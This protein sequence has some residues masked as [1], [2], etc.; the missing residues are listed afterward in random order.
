ML[1]PIASLLEPLASPPSTSCHG[2]RIYCKNIFCLSHSVRLHYTT[3]TSPFAAATKQLAVDIA[4]TSL[5]IYLQRAL[6]IFFRHE[7]PGV[8]DRRRR[9]QFKPLTTFSR[10]IGHAHGTS[11]MKLYRLQPHCY[12]ITT[13]HATPTFRVAPAVRRLWQRSCTE[14]LSHR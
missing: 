6:N 4:L 11:C 2:G 3:V 5:L 9:K 12:L 7:A 8:F 10:R 1:S 13:P 14:T